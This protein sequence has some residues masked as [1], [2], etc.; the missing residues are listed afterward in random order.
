MTVSVVK[1]LLVEATITGNGAPPAHLDADILDLSSAHFS[2]RVVMICGDNPHVC[3]VV[4]SN[5]ELHPVD[6][7][8]LSLVHS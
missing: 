8:L 7:D 6:K 5:G 2:S 3:V 1:G 4:M